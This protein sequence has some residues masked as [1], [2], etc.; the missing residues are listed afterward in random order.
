MDPEEAM[1][2]DSPKNH[3]AKRGDHV[4]FPPKSK[5]LQNMIYIYIFIYEDIMQSGKS[6]YKHVIVVWL[7]VVW[8]SLSLSP[9]PAKKQSDQHRTPEKAFDK[10][11]NHD[12][13]RAVGHRRG[14][15]KSPGGSS[16]PNAFWEHHCI[17][18][19]SR[20]DTICKKRCHSTSA[21]PWLAEESHVT[22][23]VS[24]VQSPSI[25][26]RKKTVLSTCCCL[27][28]SSTHWTHECL[29]WILFNKGKEKEKNATELHSSCNV[30]LCNVS[31]TE[32]TPGDSLK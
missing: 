9:F 23:E 17:R 27:C 21:V 13:K 20:A 3:L 6:A 22:S 28:V 32:R 7:Y 25:G 14:Q 19:R 11:F 26:G 16:K 30:N 5:K 29:R 10:I 31:S 18:K 24:R 4:E 12:F 15:K 2:E 1:R 8:I